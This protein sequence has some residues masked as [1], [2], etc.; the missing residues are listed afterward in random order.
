M[1][2]VLVVAVVVV[3][4][5]GLLELALE[6]SPTP[7]SATASWSLKL[8]KLDRAD[9]AVVIAL[10][11]VLLEEW[12]DLKESAFLLLLLVMVVVVFDEDRVLAGAGSRVRS[13]KTSAASRMKRWKAIVWGKGGENVCWGGAI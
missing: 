3:G 8:V 2:L 9:V 6:R 12:W 4:L 7:P 5:L 10:F 11:S 13:C 1:S